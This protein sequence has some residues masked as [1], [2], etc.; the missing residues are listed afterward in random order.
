MQRRPSIFRR[1]MPNRR[2]TAPLEFVLALPLF[3]LLFLALFAM[4]GA[5]QYRMVAIERTRL[6]TWKSLPST[7][8]LE[9]F[10]LERPVLDGE[11]RDITRIPYRFAGR[12]G[13]QNDAT[14]STMSISGTWDYRTVPFQ[15]R[16]PRYQ[17]HIKPAE[18][19]A[20]SWRSATGV[21]WTQQ[22]ISVRM[23]QLQS[24]VAGW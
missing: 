19:L 22:V 15:D 12:L 14:S 1:P 5:I 9:Q 21:T 3:A 8:T 10:I 4:A 18:Q 13:G 2:G 16:V 11:Q 20:E 24:Q 23:R 17:G 6:A 7:R